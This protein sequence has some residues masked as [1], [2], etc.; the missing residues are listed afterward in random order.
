MF[1]VVPQ[2][3][4]TMRPCR[5]RHDIGTPNACHT[6]GPSG[7]PS[8]ALIERTNCQLTGIDIDAAG[9]AYAQA[10]ATARGLADRGHFQ[11]PRL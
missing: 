1:S 5:F 9:I 3:L 7:V 6:S 2:R 8:L 10:Q 4:P 11:R